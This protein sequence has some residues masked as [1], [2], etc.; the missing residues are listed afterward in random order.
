MLDLQVEHWRALAA[1]K[2]A[3]A[4]GRFQVSAPTFEGRRREIVARV[5]REYG[6]PLQMTIERL[7][8]A[9]WFDRRR[10]NMS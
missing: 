1:K 5:L 4:P 8:V 10:S 9:R 2:E 6:S 7:S 3:P